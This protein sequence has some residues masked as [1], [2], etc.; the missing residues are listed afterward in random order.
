M[1]VSG[2]SHISDG[3][4]YKGH[5]WSQIG[6]INHRMGYSGLQMSLRWVVGGLEIMRVSFEKFGT[7][8]K[9]C[10]N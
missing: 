3:M 6:Y 9:L 10:G 1:W 2:R 7:V 8:E 4:G 5:R